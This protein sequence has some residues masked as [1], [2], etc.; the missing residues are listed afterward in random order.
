M[1]YQ[2]IK[3]QLN[4]YYFTKLPKIAESIKQNVYSTMEEYDK[5]N[6]NLNSYQ[7]KAKLYEV[8]TDNLQIKIFN[9]IPFFFETGALVAFSDGL[10]SRGAIHANGWL[11]ER[12]RHLFI[13]IDP[14]AYTRHRQS[15]QLY[16]QSSLY[17]DMMHLGLPFISHPPSVKVFSNS[18]S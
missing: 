15:F 17:A 14:E 2:N 11:Y 4:D 18:Y 10:Y 8:I 7:L 9:E 16:N 1:I 6:P 5:E 3:N 12:N 13:D